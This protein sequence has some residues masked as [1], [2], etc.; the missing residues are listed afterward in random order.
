[1]EL[2]RCCLGLSEQAAF[3]PKELRDLLNMEGITVHIDPEQLVLSPEEEAEIKGNRIKRRIHDVLSAAEKN[4]AAAAALFA[5]SPRSVIRIFKAGT[6][7]L[8]TA[9]LIFRALH[10]STVCWT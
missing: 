2:K 6:K 1:M 10:P 4:A 5:G 7:G 9:S 3:T 8:C